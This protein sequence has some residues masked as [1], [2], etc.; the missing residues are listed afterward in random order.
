MEL[1]TLNQALHTIRNNMES[2]ATPS[3][4]FQISELI[5]K[6]ETEQ[7]EVAAEQLRIRTTEANRFSY[8]QEESMI[9]L[10]EAYT[11]LQTVPYIEY[12]MKV[13]NQ[14]RY[15]GINYSFED[16][17]PATESSMAEAFTFHD[18][19]ADK[20][21]D[22]VSSAACGEDAADVPGWWMLIG[23]IGTNPPQEML[24]AFL[25]GRLRIKDLNPD[26]AHHIFSDWPTFLQDP[27][28]LNF[29]LGVE[30]GYDS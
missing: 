21:Q 26:E 2:G 23:L 7:A 24:D 19:H 20:W 28:T 1:N 12:E 6:V 16:W 17:K 25:D 14:I 11:V 27:K 5:T 4:I 8:R 15:N 18:Q 29:E 30:E 3:A 10:I 22:A 9:D 13:Y